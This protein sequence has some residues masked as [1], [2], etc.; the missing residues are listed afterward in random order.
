MKIVSNTSPIIFLSK[1]KVLDLIEKEFKKIILPK[2]VYNE[3][4]KDKNYNQNI[5]YIKK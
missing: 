5:E 3:L 2:A 4:T 1:L